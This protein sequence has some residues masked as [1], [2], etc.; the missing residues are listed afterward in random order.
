MTVVNGVSSDWGVNLGHSD[1]N[2]GGKGSSHLALPLCILSGIFHS[3]PYTLRKMRMNKG[4][5]RRE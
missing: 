5:C 2:R 4:M 1:Q 3:E